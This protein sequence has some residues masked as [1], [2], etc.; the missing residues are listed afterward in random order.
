M[1]GQNRKK[2]DLEDKLAKR[3]TSSTKADTC[4]LWEEYNALGRNS[5]ATN[6]S[7][8][9]IRWAGIA[10]QQIYQKEYDALGGNTNIGRNKRATNISRN[11]MYWG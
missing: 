3:R 11:M 6:I 2:E 10:G 1:R 4:A 8:N 7:R 5:R 9:M